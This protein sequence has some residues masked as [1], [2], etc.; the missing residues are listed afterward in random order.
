MYCTPH[1]T[2]TRRFIGGS[3][4]VGRQVAGALG[5]ARCST[6]GRSSVGGRPARQRSSLGVRMGLLMA[7]RWAQYPGRTVGHGILW[8]ARVSVS[9]TKFSQPKIVLSTTAS[10]RP[11]SKGRTFQQCPEQIHNFSRRSHSASHPAVGAW[12]MELATR[13]RRSQ[14]SPA[15]LHRNSVKSI[16]LIAPFKFHPDV[17]F[18]HDTAAIRQLPD[19]R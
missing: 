6:N 16:L 8:A 4:T 14:S 19:V 13:R 18:G 10:N 3:V 11:S 7:L 2:V 5:A 15:A 9:R 12:M 17:F 1:T